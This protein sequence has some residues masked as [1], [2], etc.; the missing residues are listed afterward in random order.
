M[1]AGMLDN[2]GMGGESGT[3]ETKTRFVESGSNGR[4]GH[5]VR[6][7]IVFNVHRAPRRF[8]SQELNQP[9]SPH[10]LLVPLSA[11]RCASS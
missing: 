8:T 1:V 2:P 6:I 4:A 11:Q 10:C 9:S 5:G 7:F 3:T